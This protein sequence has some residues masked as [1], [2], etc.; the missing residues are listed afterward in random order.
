VNLVLVAEGEERNRFPALP[1]DRAPS[2]G[3][4]LRSAT[5]SG[6]HAL[7][8]TRS[9]TARWFITLGAKG[10]IAAGARLEAATRWG[11][12]PQRDIHS[13][14]QG[15]GWT[16]RRGILVEALSTLV[17]PDGQRPRDRRFA[18]K[19]APLSP[20]EKAMIAEAANR[21]DEQVTKRQL[22]VDRWVHDV[23]W[24]EALELL[25]SRPTGQHRRTRGRVHRPGR[26][27]ILPHRA[28]A[29]LDLRL[30]PDRRP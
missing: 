1:P 17:S 26:Q 24:R 8:R 19:R 21:L 28:V 12:G 9:S 23:S 20:A 5:R 7:G 14:K 16:V 29:K 15:R 13:S 4:W 25:M 11:R 3:G 27:D 22:G 18:D 6:F 30:V 2:R 10:V